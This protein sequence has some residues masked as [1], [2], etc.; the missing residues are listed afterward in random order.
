M[1]VAIPQDSII[2]EIRADFPI[3]QRQVHGHPL[4]YLDNAATS[5]KPLAVIQAMD[6]YYRLTNANVHRG[7]HTLSEEA[8]A[9]Y[10]GAR[11]R[12][13]RFV[14]ASSSKEIIFTRNATEAINLVAYS[15]GMGTLKPGD[16]VL[17]TEMEHHSNIVPWQIICERTGATLRYVPIDL[18]GHLRLDLLDELLTE[19]T[20]MFAFV[21]MSNVLGTINPVKQMVAAAGAVGALTLVDG[22]QSVPH[23][24]VDVQAQ[25]ADFQVFSGHKMLGPTGSGVLHG[26]QELLEAM[27]PFMGGGD[28]IREVRMDGS[29]WNSLPWKFEAGTPAIAEGIGLGAAVDYLSS[30]GMDWV[31]QHERTLVAYAMERLAEVE[32]LRILGPAAEERGGVVA[33]TLEGIHPHD[34]AAILDHEGIAVRAGHHCAQPIHDCYGIIASAR[35]SFYVY[36]TPEEVDRLVLALEKVQELFSF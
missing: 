33:F 31:Q 12:I 13:A 22:A 8:T 17:V 32:G 15:W 10:E 2:E 35:A 18:A 21:A 36:N 11:K 24:S 1:V 19:R 14:N 6:G 20:K 30:L 23:M 26:R 25:G 34:I 16:E 7:V 28:M 9:L 29:Q 27:P 3:L 4:A 5:Q